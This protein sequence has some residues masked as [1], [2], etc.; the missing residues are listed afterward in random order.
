MGKEDEDS[1]ELLYAA[2]ACLRLVKPTRTPFSVVQYRIMP[3]QEL[4]V[5]SFAPPD[6]PINLQ[7]SEVLKQH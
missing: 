1:K 2:F 3:N 4:D 6:P 5:F 7:R